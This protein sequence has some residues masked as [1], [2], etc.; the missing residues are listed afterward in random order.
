[1]SYIADHWFGR[2][3]LGWSFWVNL[4]ALRVL[5]IQLEDLT[6]PP[7]ITNPTTI[8]AVSAVFFAVFHIAVFIWQVIGVVRAGDKHLKSLGDV[9]LVTGSQIGVG[10]AIIAS[11]VSVSTTVQ[12]VLPAPLTGLERIFLAHKKA[13]AYE[14]TTTTEPTVLRLSGA[15][16]YG[17]AAALKERLDRNEKI[18]GLE[19]ASDGGL[20]YEARRLAKLVHDREL[21]TYV[22]SDCSSACTTVFVGGKQRLIGPNG[23]L[24]FHQYRQVTMNPMS[25][26]SDLKSEQVKDLEFFAKQNISG[27]F[28]DRI[29]AMPHDKL[30]QP[31]HR[32]LIE[33]GVVNRVVSSLK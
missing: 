30:W 12:T 9:H 17:A 31:T 23:R 2:Q 28:R 4:V 22:F 5:I 25:P 13:N 3:S 10:I 29:F 14:L 1:M 8:I 27:A 19:L 24:G 20:I 11:L 18:V 16:N 26:Q 21:T 33:A 7:F 6:R 15:I 32:E